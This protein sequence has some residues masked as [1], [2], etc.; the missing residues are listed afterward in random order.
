MTTPSGSLSLAQEH[1]RVML[2]DCAT[3]RALCGAGNR[4]GALA[5][6]HHEGLPAPA[7]GTEHTAA[8]HADLRPW[9]IVFM[10]DQ[11]GFSR[12]LV[13]TETFR[14]AG[15]LRLRLARTCPD[16]TGADE[17]T[18]DAMLEWKNIIG[19]IIGELCELATAGDIEH[20]AFDEIGVDFGPFAAAPELAATQGLWQGVELSV[21]WGGE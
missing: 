14:S 6:L 2:A 3:F 16:V 15:R 12:R 10:A 21:A 7:N 11:R 17:P 9:G 13:S 20:L 19:G 5:H 18:S 4:A 8:E 1:L